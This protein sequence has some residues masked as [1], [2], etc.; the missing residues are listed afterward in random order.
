MCTSGAGRDESRFACRNHRQRLPICDHVLGG[1]GGDLDPSQVRAP[2]IDLCKCG[3]KH[4]I[5]EPWER[6]KSHMFVIQWDP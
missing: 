6:F 3:I 4:L 2:L 5:V 1:L